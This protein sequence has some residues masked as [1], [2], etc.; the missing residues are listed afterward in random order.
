MTLRMMVS[1]LHD[2]DDDD[3]LMLQMRCR[4]KLLGRSLN[5][6]EIGNW[7]GTIIIINVIIIYIIVIII[8]IKHKFDNWSG[9]LDLM[10]ISGLFMI[11]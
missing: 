3:H 5:P 4:A 8:I 10:M 9:K 1:Y 2:D 6:L 7:T 11:L